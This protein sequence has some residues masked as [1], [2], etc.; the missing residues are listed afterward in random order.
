MS[1]AVGRDGRHEIKGNFVECCSCGHTGKLSDFKK[2]DQP[3]PKYAVEI[4]LSAFDIAR[5]G[6]DAVCDMVNEVVYKV[7]EVVMEVSEMKMLPISFEDEY[8]TYQCVPTGYT[9]ENDDEPE[10]DDDIEYTNF[11]ECTCG[12]KWEDVHD[13][14]CNDRCPECNKEI[15]PYASEDA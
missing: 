13:C 3:K 11:Y 1:A 5:L 10:D 12:A 8:V 15:E 14:Q 7:H 4:E 6:K 9:I 2:G